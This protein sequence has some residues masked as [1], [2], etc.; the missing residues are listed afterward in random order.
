MRRAF[1]FDDRALAA[2]NV[3]KIDVERISGKRRG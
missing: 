2:V 3:W 1:A